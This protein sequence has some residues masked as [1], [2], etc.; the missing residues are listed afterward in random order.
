MSE[1]KFDKNN[2]LIGF[3]IIEDSTDDLTE[4]SGHITFPNPR[5]ANLAW[6]NPVE[7]IDKRAFDTVV[8]ERD[9]LRAEIG[10]LKDE[11]D[12]TTDAL[13]HQGKT[14]RKTTENLLKMSNNKDAEIQQ[15][16]SELKVKDELLRECE[17]TIRNMHL[18][19]ENSA[20]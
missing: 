4:W 18:I 6:L 16:Q 3:M 8:K 1:V 20:R 15:L 5:G 19:V 2:P 7:M 17:R 9:D 11:L 10:T 14:L 12:R 13:I